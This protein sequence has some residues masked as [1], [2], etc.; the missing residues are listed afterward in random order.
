MAYVFRT[1]GKNGK[2]HARWR[3]QYTDYLGH[4]RTA[5]GTTSKQETAKLAEQVQAEHDLIRKGLRPLPRISGAHSGR[6][7]KEV[8]SEYMMWGESQG[9]RGGRAWAEHHARMRRSRIDWWAKTLALETLADIQGML[10]RVEK[11]LR[12]LQEEGKSGKTLTNYAE[13]LR[14]FCGWC[15][16][17]GYLDENPLKALAA[18]DCTPRTNR[19][20]IT[21][22][23]LKRLFEI[24]PEHRRLLYCVALVSGLRVG[25]LRALALEDLDTVNNGLRLHAEWTKNRKEGWQPLPASIVERLKAFAESGEPQAL[26]HRFKVKQR[27]TREVPENPLLYVPNNPAGSLDCDLAAAG[28]PKATKEGKIDFHALR[29]AFV[30]F[31]IEA[32]ATVK[33]AQLLAR[34]SAANL[35][36]NVYARAREDR[37]SELAHAVGASIIPTGNTTGAQQKTAPFA[38]SCAGRTYMVGEEGLEPSSPY[39]ERILSPSCMPVPPL[40]LNYQ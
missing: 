11:A 22:E 8:S 15:V 18:F 17:R 3:F 12:K 34:H 5:T 36:M 23:E 31:V 24:A 19:R 39:G 21:R 40:R 27:P 35:T 4:R 26:Y 6:Q 37:L 1:Q 20:A 25:E 7:F 14:H 30:S 10:P 33:E 29:V 2:A 38:S 32:G 13:T 28:I 9:G 16:T